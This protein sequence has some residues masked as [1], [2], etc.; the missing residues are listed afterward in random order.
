[1]EHLPE[2]P[3]YRG[4]SI[5][6]ALVFGISLV[7]YLAG[8]GS[9]P[10]RETPPRPP[11]PTAAAPPAISYSG[12]SSAPRR[13]PNAGWKSSDLESA[14]V[15]QGEALPPGPARDAALVGALEARAERRAYDGAPPT[16]PH[17]IDQGGPP[18][19]LACHAEGMAFEG[20]VAP[21]MSHAA[22]TSCT[23]C[24]APEASPPPWRG[25][26]SLS[27]GNTFE[28]LRSV[29]QGERAW[30]GAPPTIPHRTTLR[31]ACASCHGPHGHPA[32]RSTH[33]PRQSCTQCH[34]P[35]AALDQ[36]EIPDFSLF[37]SKEDNAR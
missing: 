8:T 15:P 20:R 36:R 30:E 19:C 35:S 6:F 29:A 14:Q 24:H 23:Q 7:G 25:G 34:A 33:L 16:I 28:G 18:E 10:S 37:N 1:M 12:L 2:N 4:L 31:E 27:E 9:P 5:G 17:P 21:K 26:P 3:G 11:S 32:I 22:Y 13:G